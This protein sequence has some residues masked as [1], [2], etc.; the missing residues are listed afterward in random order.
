[1]NKYKCI[2]LVRFLEFELI[3]VV[4]G[5]G[6]VIVIGSVLLDFDVVLLILFF[7]WEFELVLL[8]L[9]VCMMFLFE[10]EDLFILEV[11]EVELELVVNFVINILWIGVGIFDF[12]YFGFLFNED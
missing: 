9:D 7:F 12:L 3:L 1:M 2:F 11:L 8:L 4:L 6:D 5:V 10:V